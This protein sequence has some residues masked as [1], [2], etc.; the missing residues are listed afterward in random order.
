MRSRTSP[1]AIV[2]GGGIIGAFISFYL[3][4]EGVKTLLLD[5]GDFAAETSASCEG[6][7]TIHN[8]TIGKDMDLAQE[9]LRLYRG[10]SRELGGEIEYRRVGGM[11][12]AE[13]EE[14]AD[15]LK[16]R[17]KAQAHL[18]IRLKWLDQKEALE[19]E[20]CLAQDISG[21]SF[22]EVE[23]QINPM[24]ATFALVRNARERGLL[25]S[26][27]SKVTGIECKNGKV[28]AVRIGSRRILTRL[29]MNAAG[30]WASDIARMVRIEVPIIPRR[31]ML[32]VSEPIPPLVRHFLTEA[33]YLTLK[34]SPKEMERSRS[35]RVRKGVGFVI[36]QTQAGTLVLGSSRQFAGYTNSVEGSVV[37]HIIRR[38]VRFIPSLRKISAIRLYSGLRPYTPD[39][40]PFIGQT[41]VEGFLMAAGQEGSGITL[42][43]IT[44]KLVS[45]IVTGN[46]PTIPVGRFLLSRFTSSLL[47]KSF[48]SGCSKMP[49]CKA[50]EI[51][52]NEAYLGVRRNDEG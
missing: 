27:F 17:V 49:R 11:M 35:E 36:E 16:E 31:G 46:N 15:R 33:S 52:R 39:N 1:E 37:R 12:I 8:K 18:G 41:E 20:P 43:P 28:V 26:P 13:T 7:I 48:F 5:R 44:G 22:C 50:P 42:A 19:E 14:E 25:T 34:L 47:K 32:V 21:A 2:I 29:A 9:S 51:L 38:G 10:L 24:A 45:E 4:R 23:A 30:V 40:L 6:G 3:A